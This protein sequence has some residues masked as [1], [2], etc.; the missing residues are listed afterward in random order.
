M[1]TD[2]FFGQ[3]PEFSVLV[4]EEQLQHEEIDKGRG[5]Y[6]G[7]KRKKWKCIRKNVE[8][9]NLFLGVDIQI[10]K[11]ME[12]SKLIIVGRAKGKHYSANYIS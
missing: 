9:L 3:T 10:G 4:Q 6:S 12:A 1:L 7:S 8:K 11:A 2:D 5:Q